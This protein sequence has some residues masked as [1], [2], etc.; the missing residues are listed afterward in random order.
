MPRL[1]NL[2]VTAGALGFVLAALLVTIL[3]EFDIGGVA[4]LVERAGLGIW[5]LVLLTF[6]LGTTFATAQIAFAV[7]QLAEPEE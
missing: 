7:M 5:P 6:S 1:V 4:T 2:F 3:W